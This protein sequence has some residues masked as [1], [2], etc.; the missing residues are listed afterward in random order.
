MRKSVFFVS[1]LALAACGGGSGGGTSG[2]IINPTPGEIVRPEYEGSVS[3]DIVD[4]NKKILS[5][6]SSILD[7]TART[8]YLKE[9]FGE[10]GYNEYLAELRGENTETEVS[11]Q[12]LTN[13]AGTSRKNGNSDKNICKSEHDC[14]QK[15]FDNMLAV[16]NDLDNLD[17]MD[18][19]D[20]KNA[21]IA[22]GFKD[23]IPGTWD[24]IKAWIRG[25][26]TE[27]I[28]QGGEV[29]NDPGKGKAT[30]FKLN[31]AEFK[32]MLTTMKTGLPA[33]EMTLNIDEKTG[34]VIGIK[35]ADVGSGSGEHNPEIFYN[36]GID[37]KEATNEF[38]FDDEVASNSSGSFKMESYANVK[39]LG[40]RYS[41][42]GVLVATDGTKVNGNDISGFQIPFVGGYEVKHIAAADIRNNEDLT[43]EIFFKGIAKGTVEA[44]NESGKPAL[45]IEDNNAYL[46]FNRENGSETLSANFDNWYRVDIS[47]TPEGG[48]GF[49]C[50]ADGKTIDED[51]Q[52]QHKP[53]FDGTVPNEQVLFDTAYY[54][55]NKTP[56]EAVALF[57][58]Q[59]QIGQDK[60]NGNINVFIGFGGKKA[61]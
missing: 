57:Q 37:R 14:N 38:V 30:E 60:D 16:L 58:Y 41:D 26:A 54:G 15:I 40:L 34:E 35:F 53:S 8:A 29:L 10:D 4:S 13:R 36:E 7:E 46:A 45:A 2:G 50:N 19:K 47:K 31:N 27:I 3:A 28:N 22:A 32:T 20:V 5:M 6:D 9:Q 51:Y 52:L 21:L 59:Q 44:P 55:D 39:E 11:T 43:E 33:D 18:E 24:D 42:F 56:E 25:N 23:E 49:N 1:L 12:S 61:E 17:T 48:Y